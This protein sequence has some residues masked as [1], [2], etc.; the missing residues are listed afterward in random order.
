MATQVEGEIAFELKQR[1]FLV[2]T[3]LKNLNGKIQ[4]M[5]IE[6]GYQYYI[7]QVG[8]IISIEDHLLHSV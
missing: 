6:K 7:C 3:G 4:D 2:E 1:L 5:E 8:F